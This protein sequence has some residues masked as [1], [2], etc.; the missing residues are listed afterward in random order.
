MVAHEAARR[1]ETTGVA[2]GNCKTENLRNVFCLALCA[3]LGP[4]RC[5]EQLD[6]VLGRFVT[7]SVCSVF[8]FSADFLLVQMI[9]FR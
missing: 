4:A 2:T 1:S 5:Q 6:S 9:Y 7:K 8:A 3:E